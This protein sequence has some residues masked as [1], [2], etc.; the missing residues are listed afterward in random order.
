LGE[1]LP[2]EIEASA[3]LLVAEALTNVVKHARAAR[4][5]VTA[6]VEDGML[7]VEVRDDGIG[8][9]DASGHGLVGMDD[10][11]SALG[12]QLRST[13]PRTAARSSPRRF[14]LHPRRRFSSD[15]T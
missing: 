4:A 13:A 3:Y 2:A 5:E 12:G 15:Q 8:G 10:R 9:A 14:R 7:R 6:W 1:R 11:A